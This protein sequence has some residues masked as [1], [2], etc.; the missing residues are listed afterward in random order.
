MSCIGTTK[1]VFIEFIPLTWFFVWKKYG[2]STNPKSHKDHKK[3]NNKVK[4]LDGHFG[5]HHHVGAKVL[6]GAEQLQ[7]PDVPVG[8]NRGVDYVHIW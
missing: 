7:G 1:K 4:H 5:N 8:H 6:V 3:E 2:L